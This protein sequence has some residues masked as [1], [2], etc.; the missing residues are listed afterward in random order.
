[1]GESIIRKI[2]SFPYVQIRGEEFYVKSWPVNNSEDVKNVIFIKDLC[3]DVNLL[4][5]GYREKY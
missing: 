1:M 5:Y 4:N 3:H 2:E